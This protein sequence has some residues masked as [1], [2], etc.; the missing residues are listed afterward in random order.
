MIAAMRRTATLLCLLVLRAVPAAAQAGG[1]EDRH[2]AAVLRRRPHDG[3]RRLPAAAPRPVERSEPGRPALALEV[4]DRG[5]RLVPAVTARDLTLEGAARGLL[6]LAGT[7]QLRFPPNRLFEMPCGLEGRS[8]VCAPRPEDAARAEAELPAADRAL[9]RM[10]RGSAGTNAEPA[11]LPLARTRGGARPLA[12]GRRRPDPLGAVE[13]P[14]IGWT[15]S[16]SSACSGCSASEGWQPDP[17]SAS[18]LAAV[19]GGD[20]AALRASMKRSRRGCSAWPTPSCATATPRP[21]RCRTPSCAISQRAGQFDP[22]RGAAAAWLAGIVRHAALDLARRRGRELPTDDPALGD[23][24]VAPEALE[25]VAASAEGRRLRDCLARWRRRTAT[26]SCS[27][28]CT[29]CRMPRWRKPR[30]AARHGEGLDPPR[31]AAAAGVPGMIPTGGARRP[32][33]RI[34]ARHAGGAA[35]RAEVRRRC[36]GNAALREAVARLGGDGSRRS[37]PSRRTKRRR[38]TSG[39]RIEAALPG[40]APA[41]AVPRQGFE[42]RQFAALST[43]GAAGR[44]APARWRPAWPRFCWSAPGPDAPLMTVLLTSRDQPAWL[45]EADRGGALRLASL[46]PRPCRPTA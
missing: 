22:A 20:R 13:P 12:P 34:R 25:R 10:V 16:C 21:T 31:P 15:A 40:R 27:P 6:A 24:A 7:A 35:R 19:A 8:L 17:I 36:R 1:R 32:G 41:A 46:N 28:S 2:L 44:W 26:A 45:V 3:P 4:M 33:R 39:A 29:A 23:T 5:G 9:V 43:P 14:A 30:P 18:L 42:R 11:E 38:P 37:P